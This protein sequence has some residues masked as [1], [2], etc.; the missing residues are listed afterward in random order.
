[1]APEWNYRIEVTKWF[2]FQPDLR[3]IVRPGVRGE[4]PNAAA[5]GARAVID[6]R[7]GCRDPV[8]SCFSRPSAPRP[9]EARRCPSRSTSRSP[10]SSFRSTIRRGRSIPF[11]DV[12]NHQ[13]RDMSAEEAARLVAD[14]DRLNMK[15]MVNLSGSRGAEFEKGY[16]QPAGP[17]SR[18]LRRLR[19]PRLHGP[20][21]GRAG[22]QRA[23]AQLAE[24]VRH[25]AQGLKIFKDLGLTVVDTLGQARAGGRS[26]ARPRLGQVR[27]ARHPGAHPL[28]R[29]AVLLRSRRTSSTSAGWS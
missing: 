10:R 8:S 11:I 25:G 24:D 4:I 9:P 22:A 28:R 14:M 1:M 6:F 5:I 16:P 20:R 15:V 19:E 27:R 18:P 29:A 12:H 7:G 21:R 17:L 13:D 26:A 3:W 23:V 2:T